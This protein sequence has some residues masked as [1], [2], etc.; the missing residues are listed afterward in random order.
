MATSGEFTNYPI[1]GS[2]F[3]LRATWMASYNRSGNAPTVTVTQ[4]AYLRY[5]NTIDT[6]SFFCGSSM[7]GETSTLV[8]SPAIA[9]TTTYYKQKTLDT[10]SHTFALTKRAGSDYIYDDISVNMGAFAGVYSQGVNSPVVYDGNNYYLSTSGVANVSGLDLTPVTITA[11][12]SN[13]TTSSAQVTLTAN[14]S[15]STW[16][17]SV[18]GG[19]PMLLSSAPAT[20]CVFTLSNLTAGTQYTLSFSG[21]TPGPEYLSSGT[22]MATFST[23]AL[24]PPTITANISNV[25]TD[26]AIVYASSDSTCKNWVIGLNGTSVYTTPNESSSINATIPVTRGSTYT[27][28]VSATSAAND[29]VGTSSSISFTVPSKTTFLQSNY[30]VEWSPTSVDLRVQTVNRL[31]A[32]SN[33]THVLTLTYSSNSY[34]VASGFTISGNTYTMTFSDACKD[35]ILTQLGNSKSGTFG[36]VLTTKSSDGTT[37]YG[38]DNANLDVALSDESVLEPTFT[39]FTYSDSNTATVAVTGDNQ[40]L[41]SGRSNL[42]VS[43]NTATAKDGATIVSYTASFG[44]KS[45]SSSTTNINVGTVQAAGT[46]LLSV[47]AT[48]SRGYSTTVTKTVTSLPYNKPAFSSIE[49][50]RDT[51]DD[52]YI[53]VNVVGSFQSILV[54]GVEKNAVESFSYQYRRSDSLTWSEATSVIPTVSGTSITFSASQLVQLSKDYSWYV[55]FSMSD[56]FSSDSIDGTMLADVPLISFRQ[57]KVGINNKTPNKALDVIGEIEMNGFNVQGFVR[58]SNN[59]DLDDI[60]ETG[61]YLAEWASGDLNQSHYPVQQRG[62]LEVLPELSGVTQRFTRVPVDGRVWIRNGSS[63]SFGSWSQISGSGSVTI[64]DQLSYTSEN[65]VQ[66]KVITSSLDFK[67]DANTDGYANR[68]MGIPFGSVAS[69]STAT[70][71]TATIPGITELKNGVCMWLK[72]G[73]ITSASGFTI[74]VNGLGAKPVY[75][76]MAAATRITTTFNVAYT[77][78]FVYDEDRVA[79]G[80]WM[81]Y[82]GYNSDT[83]TIAYN[84]RISQSIRPMLNQ[85]YRYQVLFT[86]TDGSLI[87]ANTY[88]NKPA[89]LDKTLMTDSFNPFEPIYY[90]TTTSAVS[91]GSNPSASY[92]Y[93]QY[94]STDLRYSFNTGTTLIAGDPIYIQCSPQSDGSVKLSGDDCIVQALPNTEDGYVYILLGYAYDNYR[95]EMYLEKPVYW[96]KNG[97]IR[98]WTNEA[99]AQTYYASPVCKTEGSIANKIAVCNEYALVSN[100]WQQVIVKHANTSASAITLNINGTGAVP[101]YINGTASSDSNYTI[102]AGC[103]FV[104]YDGNAYQF[105][106]DGKLPGRALAADSVPWGGITNRPTLSVVSASSDVLIINDV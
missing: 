96:Y 79:G 31:G 11:D 62:V 19:S 94:T 26:A 84:I 2:Q 14:R 48:D 74:N 39:N 51:T 33:D 29:V 49:V 97:A 28:I 43:A 53:S 24:T 20:S 44:G 66:N 85:L 98:P 1:S 100:S 34:Q 71:F 50:S 13:I 47:T 92:L 64:D 81:M 93:K 90:Y 77:M 35:W 88:S 67:A 9:D 21:T 104:Y 25:F 87:A 106:T 5:I 70:L 46:A 40:I 78:L 99:D 83:N 16:S 38:T 89:Q 72:N 30:S 68:T 27:L 56:K 60:L 69:T 7:D 41:I 80:C 10:I 32:S 36:I 57:Q 55:R 82:Y 45:A 8:T 18:N 61:I 12:I 15:C 23:V 102:P 54:N 65:P 103:Y 4:V 3:G 59:E 91:P 63:T 73:V 42:I 17:Y 58:T 105:R 76:S 101:I 75:N 37:T 52:S 22:Q 95:I 6:P 86:G